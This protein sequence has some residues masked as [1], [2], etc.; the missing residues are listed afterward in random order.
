MKKTIDRIETM[1]GV[2]GLTDSP[3]QLFELLSQNKGRL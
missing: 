2:T 3:E 1:L